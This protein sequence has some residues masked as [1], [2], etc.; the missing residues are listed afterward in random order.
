[1][2]ITDSSDVECWSCGLEQPIVFGGEAEDRVV[3]CDNCGAT[4][5]ETG[6]DTLTLPQNKEQAMSINRRN[7]NLTLIQRLKEKLGWS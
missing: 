4:I 3:E 5:A 6:I 7:N 2:S 1:M